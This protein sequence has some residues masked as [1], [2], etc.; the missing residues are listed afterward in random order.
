MLHSI[1]EEM[2]NTFWGSVRKRVPLSTDNKFLQNLDKM[3]EATRTKG[4]FYISV[5]MLILGTILG[6][7]APYIK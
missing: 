7:I 3:M 4:F 6:V 1:G 2:M 5:G